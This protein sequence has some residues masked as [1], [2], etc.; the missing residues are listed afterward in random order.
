[1]TPQQSGNFRV[2]IRRMESITRMLKMNCVSDCGTPACAIGEACMV[3]ALQKQGL[4]LLATGRT[5]FLLWHGKSEGLWVPAKILFG[6]EQP[7]I[8][9]LFGAAGMN[10]WNRD[11]V[12]P[13]EWAT[14]ARKVL[15]ANG[16]AMDDGFGKFLDKLTTFGRAEDFARLAA[17]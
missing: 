12:T 9:R 13:Q 14:E 17:L 7:D 16:Y 3:P 8:N 5:I 1:M 2:L 15:A 6:L 11:A 10:A 4:A